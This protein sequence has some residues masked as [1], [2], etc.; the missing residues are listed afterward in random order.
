M[1]ILPKFL[2]S[3]LVE[4]NGCKGMNNAPRFDA[5]FA[6]AGVQFKI[7][8]FKLSAAVQVP[9]V[10]QGRTVWDSS[11]WTNANY[12]QLSKFTFMSRLA[13]TF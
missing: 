10:D 11:Y 4:F 2:F 6:A 9:L 12:D 5:F 1:I 8:F 3:L 13:F 7:A